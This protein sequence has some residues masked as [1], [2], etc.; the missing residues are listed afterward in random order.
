[1][2]KTEFNLFIVESFSPEANSTK[3][4]ESFKGR[5]DNVHIVD[6]F[7]EINSIDK[8]EDSWYGVIYDNEIVTKELLESL[9]EFFTLSD[10]EVLVAFK[11]EVK[12]P[13][14]VTKCPRFFKGYVELSIDHLKPFLEM[15]LVHQIILNGWI[16][17]NDQ[18][19]V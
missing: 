15:K 5:I 2:I 11:R 13:P 14:R 9:E 8:K 12:E 1:M 3:T 7:F 19:R 4:I 18:N 10:A 16:E 6:S 17:E